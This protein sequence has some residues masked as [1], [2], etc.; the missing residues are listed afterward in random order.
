MVSTQDC[1]LSHSKYNPTETIQP[2]AEAHWGV[3]VQKRLCQNFGSL[4][5]PLS[6][7]FSKFSSS[8]F[9]RTS[10][11]LAAWASL[12]SFGRLHK[13]GGFCLGVVI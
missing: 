1:P 5:S 4:L 11:P 3:L 8:R 9:D 7:E 6:L 2:F 13:I 10:G 12:T